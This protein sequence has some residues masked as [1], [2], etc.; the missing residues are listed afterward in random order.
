MNG[1]WIAQNRVPHADTISFHLWK[2]VIFSS[3]SYD[4]VPIVAGVDI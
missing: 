4:Y 3:G 2:V 1:C